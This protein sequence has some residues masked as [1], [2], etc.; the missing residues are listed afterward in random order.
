MKPMQYSNGDLGMWHMFA[1]TAEH[2]KFV[3]ESQERTLISECH[4]YSYDNGA[5]EEYCNCEKIVRSSDFIS[6][7]ECWKC[8]HYSST[9]KE[10]DKK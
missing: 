3:A 4:F 6:K 1:E 7:E 2:I 5:C 9:N 8:P 10:K